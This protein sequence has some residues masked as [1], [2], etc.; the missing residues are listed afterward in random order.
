[1][2]S[3]FYIKLSTQEYPRYPGDIEIDPAGATDYAEVTWVDPPQIDRAKQRLAMGAPALVDGTYTVTWTVT[4]IPAAE[5]GKK[6]REERNKRLAACDWTQLADSPAD[7]ATWAT[8]RQALRDVPEQDT[9]PS[10]VIW[11]TE[12]KE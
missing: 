12:P 11:P 8:Y 5:Q 7:K 6:I 2:T 10:S 9:F 3:N 4:D 1:M